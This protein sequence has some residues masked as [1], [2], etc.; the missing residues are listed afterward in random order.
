MEI[1]TL[2]VVFVA[3]MATILTPCCLPV[4]PPLLSG[5]VGHRFRPIAIVSGSLLSFTALGVL[6]GS[7]TSFSPETLRAPAFLAIAA[8]GA[9]MVDD[10]LH[11]TYSNAASRLSSVASRQ[12]SIFDEGDRP[13]ASAFSL[14]TLLGVI[15]LPCVGPVLGA[16]LAYAATA[17]TALESGVFLFVYGLGFSV[18]LL[19]V[20]YGGTITGRSIATRVGILG[21][22]DAVRR[23]VGLI[24][25]G[26]GIALLFELDR[27][28]LSALS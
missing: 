11:R 13:L 27:I 5:S 4:L 7:V 18:P 3:G 2:S 26:T 6:V 28:L 10:D 24:L 20:A 19:G 14:G 1:P 22:G 23:V 17:G 15:W 8:F 12:A 16:V 25:L 21:R 9:V